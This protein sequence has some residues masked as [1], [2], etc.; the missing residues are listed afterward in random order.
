MQNTDYFKGKKVTV[1]GLA[2]S[3]LACANLLYELGSKVSVSDNQDNPSVRS[4]AKGLRS[5]DIA[6]ELGGHSEK[7]IRG[8]EL[9]ILSPGVSGSSPAVTMAE[10]LGI[11]MIS[12]VEFAFLLCPAKVI[13]ITGTNGKTTVATLVGK[14]L[15][16]WGRN[17][18]V[19]GNIGTP[20]SAE[21]PKM[22]EEDFAVV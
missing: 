6:L 18:F 12:E 13:A 3:G 22:S 5:A 8:S 1:I 7:F 19:C 20:F 17:V 15:K 10:R 14:I 9:V 11:P 4:N 16:A 21:V 2:R